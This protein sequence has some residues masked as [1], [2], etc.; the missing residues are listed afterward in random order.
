MMDLGRYL[1]LLG[2]A[3]KPANEL[4]KPKS[5]NSYCRLSFSFGL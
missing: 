5:N 2:W 4:N 1:C 3:Y